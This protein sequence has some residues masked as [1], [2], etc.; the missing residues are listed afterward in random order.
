MNKFAVA[1]TIQV[2]GSK[3]KVFAYFSDMCNDVHWRK[4]ALKAHEVN[5]GEKKLIE[6]ETFLSPKVPSIVTRYYVAELIPVNRITYQSTE[7]SPFYQRTNRSV[8]EG[9]NGLLEVTYSIEFDA[10]M[11]I[12][13]MGF[14]M[15]A[16]MVNFYLWVLIRIYTGKLKKELSKIAG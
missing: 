4:E 5:E 3:E 1:H 8:E 11:I 7:D 2:K 12:K 16:A 10:A 13:G 6:Q 9:E 14:K 15:P